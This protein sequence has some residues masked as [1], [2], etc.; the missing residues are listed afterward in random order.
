MTHPS[1]S[2]GAGGLPARWPHGSFLATLSETD[3]G[4]LLALGTGRRF[5][6]GAALVREG[7]PGTDVYVLQR[8]CVKV[9]GDTVDG[10]TTL[11]A[12]R[13]PG[14]LIGELAG[15]RTAVRSAT[16]RA[17]ARCEARCI[18]R[19][20]FD[21]Y[22][23]R[24]PAAT[25]VLLASVTAKLQQATRFRIDLAGASAT[26]RLARTLLPLYETYARP[27]GGVIDVS[28]SQ[29][30]LAALAGVAPASVFRALAALRERG[31]VSTGY[32]RVAV[33]DPQELAR[34]ARNEDPQ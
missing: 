17:A 15:Q 34:V 13:V 2:T 20:T 18:D 7:E 22:L 31:A 24:H 9:L 30:E 16:V 26:V 21:A 14:D 25:R 19:A 5:A 11:L 10:H 12:I 6:T 29:R 23:L 27:G 28:L 3:R 1:R 4:A 32:R 8:G 33:S